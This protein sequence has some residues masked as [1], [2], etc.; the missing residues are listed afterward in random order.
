M[1]HTAGLGITLTAADTSVFYSVDFNYVDYTQA[2]ARLHRIGQ[3]NNVN[4]IHLIA[5]NTIDTRLMKV[6]DNKGD[7]STTIVDNWRK[8]FE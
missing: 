2:M 4:H 5:K 8:F 3:K 6:L 1:S 7:I